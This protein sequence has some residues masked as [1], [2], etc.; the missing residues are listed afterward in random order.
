MKILKVSRLH[1]FFISLFLSIFMGCSALK[2]DL[3][4]Q[5]SRTLS[6]NWDKNTIQ[7]GD[8]IIKNKTINPLEWWGHSGVVVTDYTIGDFPQPFIGYQETGYKYWLDEDRQ[9]IVLRYAGFNEKFKEA[10]LKNVEELKKQEY[11]F[12]LNKKSVDSTY[13][14]KY[15]WY[16]YW[17]TAKDL[18]YELN[19]DNNSILAVFPYDFLETPIL[20]HINN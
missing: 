7:I 17:K 19:I 3:A 13:C 6:K 15:I 14:S 11:W 2:N 20:Q 10:F 9:V 18:G 12:T 1:I 8:I 16:L 5:D 4:W